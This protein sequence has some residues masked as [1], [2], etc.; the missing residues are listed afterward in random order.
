MLTDPTALDDADELTVLLFRQHQVLSR[1]QARAWLS[2]ATIRHRV[3]S[4]RWQQPHRAV[5]VTHN[6]P[7]SAIQRKWIASLATKSAL[8]G[9]ASALE[10]LGLRNYRPAAIHL[11]MPADERCDEP[12]SGV[13][14]H[15]TTHLPTDDIHRLGSPPCTNAARSM[16]DAAQWASTDHDA[17]S[18]VAAGFQQRLVGGD[19]VHEVLRR[20]PRARRRSLIS[21][22]ATDARGGSHSLPEVEFRRLCRRY[23]LPMPTRQLKRTDMSGRG[24]YLDAYFK[25]WRLHVE[26]DGGQH[27]EVRSWWADMKRQNEL[28]VPGDRVLRFPS[29]AVRQRP[30][31]VAE[32]VRTALIAAGWRP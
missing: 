27:M 18:I 15:R 11:L 20:M 12:P 7:I 23:G 8:L 14:I 32:Q 17:R 13:V 29:W 9:G 2:A 5:Y 10:V 16:V 6:G 22:M 26:I 30:A 1:R 25:E 3:E 31:E 24:R 4:G 21:E 19:D 28:W